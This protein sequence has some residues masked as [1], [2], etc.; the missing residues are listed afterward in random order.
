MLC[1]ISVERH[2]KE[3]NYFERC[4]K[5]LRKLRRWCILDAY[6]V[7]RSI[8]VL[9]LVTP[10]SVKIFSAGNG[11]W[12][13]FAMM[14]GV[15]WLL[16]EASRV[17]GR[18]DKVNQQISEMNQRLSDIDYHVQRKA[19]Y[20]YPRNESNACRIWTLPSVNSIKIG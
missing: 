16:L 1:S 8:F 5:R 15:M 11:P 20:D 2:K 10:S 13:A 4:C 7:F 3:R 17:D 19:L 6:T 9:V 14:L 18:I 12:R